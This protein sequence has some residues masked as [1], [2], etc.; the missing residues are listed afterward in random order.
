MD[1]PTD[2]TPQRVAAL[3]RT[4]A[5][6]SRR[7]QELEQ[8]RAAA[9]QNV[10]QNVAQNAAPPYAPQ[11]GQPAA[12][13]PYPQP[14]AYPPPQPAGYAPA[15]PAAYAPNITPGYAPNQAPLTEAE[16]KESADWVSRIGIALLVVGCGF[17]YRYSVEQGW[18]GNGL[19][20]A[21]GFA[22]AS[23]LLG[24]GLYLGS[25]RPR[26][27]DILVGGGIATFHLTF[28]TAHAYYDIIGMWPA[29]LGSALFDLVAIG[30]ALQRGRSALA[31]VGILGACASPILLQVPPTAAVFMS[32]YLAS[33]MGL[34]G[35]LA[36]LRPWAGVLGFGA[37]A[38][39]FTLIAM[40]ESAPRS[41]TLT[42]IA[43]CVAWGAMGVVPLFRRF[44]G[45]DRDKIA[46]AVA[47]VSP[48][49]VSAVGE[50]LHPDGLGFAHVIVG[51]LT[52]F[53]CAM[54]FWKKEVG[55]ASAAMAA[56]S[57]AAIAAATYTGEPWSTAL[58]AA[59]VATG[60]H[61]VNARGLDVRGVAWTAHVLAA[62]LAFGI[63]GNNQTD[64]TL[65]GPDGALKFAAVA[66]T[67]ASFLVSL[68]WA[69]RDNE[70]A[71]LI[72]GAQVLAYAWCFVDVG[73][74][75]GQGAG[76]L[77]WGIIAVAEVVW[78]AVKSNRPVL[79]LGY[80]GLAVML[81]KLLLLD[82]ATVA[83]IWRILLFMGF[84]AVF[85]ML[86]YFVPKL[87]KSPD[88]DGSEA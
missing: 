23:G 74:W 43:L 53:A 2:D 80:A 48:I 50:I 32:V 17:L 13:A 24:L 11:A 19:R 51:A 86:G 88:S 58:A 47:V 30:L 44:I 39:W 21:F 52:L 62:L 1:T 49:G 37:A 12:Y 18:I 81:L 84:G 10:A 8:A 78:G 75:A 27:S 46:Y 4:V 28:F 63:L 7:I 83:A 68:A 38:S 87:G 25:R 57:I 55:L 64:G 31:L 85:L 14:G 40:L 56:A 82:M 65:S 66:A 34:V 76:A 42:L 69:R 15:Q 29:L 72:L 60:L 41:N 16:P 54:G 6:L 45:S 3:E 35:A 77:C 79:Q 36:M 9:A 59:A 5:D 71:V 70:R 26:Y 22:L 73:H 67:L 33:I 20:V 61:F